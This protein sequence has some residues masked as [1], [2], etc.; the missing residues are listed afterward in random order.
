MF[1]LPKS[2]KIHYL[3]VLSSGR[4]HSEPNQKKRLEFHQTRPHLSS[5]KSFRKF[6]LLLLAILVLFYYLNHL[7]N[8]L[9]EKIEG[10]IPEQAE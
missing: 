2:R 5:Y 9:V 8:S 6:I 3:P 7:R 4:N 1:R 10:M